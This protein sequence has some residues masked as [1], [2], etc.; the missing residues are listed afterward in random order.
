[1]AAGKLFIVTA[2]AAMYTAQR[3]SGITADTAMGTINENALLA[4]MNPFCLLA[5]GVLVCILAWCCARRYKNTNDFKKSVYLYMPC[6]IILDLVLVFVLKIDT[7]LCIGLDLCGFVVLALIS[8]H[9]FY[10]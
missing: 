10:S 7:L 9:Y 2:D 8:N 3:I 4:V 5:G 1:M 6:V